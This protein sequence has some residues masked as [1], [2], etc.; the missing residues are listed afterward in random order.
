MHINI[1]LKKIK[2]QYNFHKQVK[3]MIL[4][5]HINNYEEE[6]KCKHN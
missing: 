5:L 4:G 3:F 1:K 2:N 6:F